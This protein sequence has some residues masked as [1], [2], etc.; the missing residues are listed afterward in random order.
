MSFSCIG[1]PV[2]PVYS[3]GIP[4][5]DEKL[6]LLAVICL[7]TLPVVIYQIVEAYILLVLLCWISEKTQIK[8]NLMI[9]IF[10]PTTNIPCFDNKLRPKLTITYSP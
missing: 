2:K 4:F 8:L 7:I 10:I 5:Y 1:Y 3:I 6:F 9:E